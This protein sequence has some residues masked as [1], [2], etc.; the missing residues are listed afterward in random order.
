MCVA[1][2]VCGRQQR[3]LLQTRLKARR[4]QR[5]V[6]NRV[7]AEEIIAL[8]EYGLDTP[9]NWE[10]YAFGDCLNDIEFLLIG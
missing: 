1:A 2:R 7:Q 3:D 4:G 10:D 5:M 9:S 6:T 8:H